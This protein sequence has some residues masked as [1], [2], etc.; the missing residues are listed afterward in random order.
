M[1]RVGACWEEG[2]GE[3][4]RLRWREV[5]RAREGGREKEEDEIKK[6]RM[7]FCKGRGVAYAR[8]AC[9]VHGVASRRPARAHDTAAGAAPSD[10]NEQGQEKVDGGGAERQTKHR[11]REV[12]GPR[13]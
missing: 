1:R 8:V 13:G 10:C 9:A 6:K 3:T 12:L 5:P 7:Q 11:K 2:K 4:P